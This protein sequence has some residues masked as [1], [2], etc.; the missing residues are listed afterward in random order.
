MTARR[1]SYAIFIAILVLFGAPE[2]ATADVSENFVKVLGRSI[3]FLSPPLS[4]EVSATIVY[5]GDSAPSRAQA[6]RIRVLITASPS[7]GPV[8][9]APRM[10]AANELTN[11]DTGGIIILTEMP[12]AEQEKAFAVAKATKALVIGTSKACANAGHCAVS[13][14]TQPSI[15]IT[16]NESTLSATGVSFDAA[17]LL[18]VDRV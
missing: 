6:K 12:S 10:S 8:T 18:L 4:G 5:A 1:G 7:A 14:Q 9:L 13:I 3:K 2:R 15:Q 11:A 17:F 16:V